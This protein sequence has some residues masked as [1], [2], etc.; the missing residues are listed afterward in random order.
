MLN[1]YDPRPTNGIS[2]GCEALSATTIEPRKHTYHVIT[3]NA[4]KMLLVHYVL[5]NLG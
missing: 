1:L 5:W 2:R 4:P 3:T